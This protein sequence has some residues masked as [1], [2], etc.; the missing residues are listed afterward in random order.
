MEVNVSNRRFYS[1]LSS[2]QNSTVTFNTNCGDS[3]EELVTNQIGKIFCIIFLF[4]VSAVTVFGNII[5]IVTVFRRGQFH[6]KISVFVISLAVADFC[7][8][9]LVMVPSII[10]YFIN[11]SLFMDP[12]RSK[13]FV[14][15]DC[16]F[17][18]SSILHFTC[19]NIDRF[20]AVSNPLKYFQIMTRRV[21]ALMIVICWVLSIVISVMFSNLSM[22]NYECNYPL[23]VQVIPSVIGSS[24]SFYLPLI[25]NIIASVKICLKVHNRNILFRNEQGLGNGT[26]QHRRHDLE[27]RVTKTIMILQGTF[28]LCVS[29]FF[30]MLILDSVFGLNI[31]DV[32]FFV[33]SWLVFT[34]S[35]I[36]PYLYYFLNKRTE[37]M[38][39]I[40]DSTR[41]LNATKLDRVRDKEEIRNT[42]NG[43][44][45]QGRVIEE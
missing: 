19:M 24:L 22:Y 20:V 21:V 44:E 26:L 17:T 41:D 36:N 3:Q 32:A 7:V 28:I 18:T 45:N 15:L 39:K 23:D 37:K 2:V 29:P 38:N 25:L 4:G 10:Q 5:L 31:S 27:V 33:L 14:A 16:L 43:R 30:V 8:A 6:R 9:V 34:N 42:Q 40:C 35:A 12:V 1:L 11:D 13:I